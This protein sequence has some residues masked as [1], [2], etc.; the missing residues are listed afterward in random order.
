M[1]ID[2]LPTIDA[3]LAADPFATAADLRLMEGFPPPPDRRVTKSNA[4]LDPPYNRWAYQHM[5]MFFPSTP[6]ASADK[7]IALDK[8]IDKGLEAIEI[9]EPDHEQS[10]DLATYLKK[11]YTDA[12]VVIHKDMIVYESFLNGMTA[13]TPHQMMSTTK[14]FCGLLSL[15]AVEDGLLSEDDLITQYVPELSVAG[16]FADAPLRHVLDMTCSMKFSEIYDDPYSDVRRYGAVLG[17]TDPAPGV[18]FEDNMY[19]FLKTLGSDD[20]RKHG[21]IMHYQGPNTDV[22]NWVTNRVTG[23]SFQ[24]GIYRHLWSKLGTEGETYV[25][26]DRCANM[27]AVGG[28]NA[29]PYNVA[30]FAVMMLNRGVFDGQQVVPPAIL[31]KLARGGSIEAFDNG[32]ESDDITFR[33][34][35]WSYRAQWWVRHTRGR[36]AIA[37]LGI[38]GQA[39]YLDLERE[40]AVVKHS[41]MPLSV[42][43]YLDSFTFNGIDSIIDYLTGK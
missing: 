38:H 4:L 1:A 34:G 26:L 28:L 20:S 25:L 35:Q 6:V 31:D 33:K 17:W 43:P 36:E 11:T 19:D 5:R 14:S 39:I 12:L 3:A 7:P 41:S 8:A 15:M 9:V 21:E 16:A 22:V 2:E 23:L 29:T 40:V 32:T 37:A 13:D 30:R 42:D 18:E 10:V 27:A 24:E